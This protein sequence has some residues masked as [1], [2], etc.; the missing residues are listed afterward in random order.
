MLKIYRMIVIISALLATGAVMLFLGCD[1]NGNGTGPGPVPPPPVDYLSQTFSLAVADGSASADGF[2]HSGVAVITLDWNNEAPGLNVVAPAYIYEY[3][4]GYPAV[5]G[6]LSTGAD[7]WAVA[8]ETVLTPGNMYGDG[9]VT[10]V[11]MKSVYTDVNPPRIWFLLRWDDAADGRQG[12]NSGYWGHRWEVVSKEG[13]ADDW[14][15]DWWDARFDL[16]EDWVAFMWDT[17]DRVY[18]G[19]D[20]GEFYFEPKTDGFQSNGCTVTCHATD[21]NP[22]HTNENGEVCDLWMW[23]GTRTNY[24]ADQT[25]WGDGIDDPAFMFDCLV[26]ERGFDWG[27]GDAFPRD[28]DGDYMEWLSFDTG[29]SPYIVNE[30]YPGTGYPDYGSIHDPGANW[31]YLWLSDESV[32]EMGPTGLSPTDE[33]WNIGDRVAA[34]VHRTAL[35]SAADVLGRGFWQNGV[36]TLEIER[37]IGIDYDDV[38]NDEDV[39]LGISET[40]SRE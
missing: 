14:W 40:G 34:Y 26:D 16:N 38:Y 28:G 9:G 33:R 11:R 5:D 3:E 23:T 10:T 29:I 36:W 17:W 7:T 21:T 8:P 25:N 4:Q 18:P 35:G 30:A 31:K 37:N 27:T 1:G 15:D 22:H 13:G 24:T 12:E 6:S 20:P 39:F 2:A 32:R 19:G